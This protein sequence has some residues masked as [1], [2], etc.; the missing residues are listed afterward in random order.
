MAY[1]GSIT[2]EISG[3]LSSPTRIQP[4]MSIPENAIRKYF[5]DNT[6]IYFYQYP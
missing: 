5:I 3:Y 1:I 6:P 4:N 2:R